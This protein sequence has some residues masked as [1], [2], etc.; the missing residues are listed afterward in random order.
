[1]GGGV[2]TNRYACG[3][4]WFVRNVKM[5]ENPD[6]EIKGV[7]DFSPRTTALIDKAFSDQ[8]GGFTPKYDSTARI[9]LTSYSP[10]DLKYSSNT[11][12][13]QLAVFSEIYYEK[14]WNAYVDG[15]PTPH[16][17]ADFV[18]RAMK[19]PAGKHEI[20]FKFEPSSYYTGEKIALAGSLLLFIFIGGGIYLDRKKQKET[21]AQAA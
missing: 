17:R 19:V 10:N 15:K 21:V 6:E 13:D 8:L 18:L 1:D 14:G 11:S 3:N 9:E 12:S 20:E 7:K 5:V 4:A 2:W 16:V